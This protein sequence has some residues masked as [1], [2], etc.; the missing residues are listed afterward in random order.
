MSL[1]PLATTLGVDVAEGDDADAL[2]ALELLDVL[3][4]TATEADDG[5]AEV[6]VGASGLGVGLGAEARHG[7]SHGGVLD[8]RATIE[9]G[10]RYDFGVKVEHKEMPSESR[11]FLANGLPQQR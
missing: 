3:I 11:M 8:E 4:A 2:D 7:G 5:D 9:L 6:T 10:H 1:R